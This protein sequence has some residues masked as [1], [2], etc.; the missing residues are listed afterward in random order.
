MSAAQVDERAASREAARQLVADWPPLT[1]EQ[2]DALAVIL[3]AG[4]RPMNRPNNGDTRPPG[5]GGRATTKKESPPPRIP[6]P[7][8][9]HEGRWPG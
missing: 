9:I 7:A 4:G 2:K 8:L 1:R 6:A 3:R 5:G